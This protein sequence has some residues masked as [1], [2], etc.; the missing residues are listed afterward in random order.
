MKLAREAHALF[1]KAPSMSGFHLLGSG[2]ESL[3]VEMNGE[4]EQ[5]SDI[6]GETAT[7]D[8]GYKPQISVSPY[9]ANPDDSIYPF[10]KDLALN[11]KSGDAGLCEYMEV[12]VDDTEASTHSAWKE[13]CRVEITSYGGDTTGFQIEFNIYPNGSREEGTVASLRNPTFV[14]KN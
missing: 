4:F 7:V 10:L 13:N 2:M 3:T 9:Y 8:K 12:V 5:T 1:L 14:P 11:R 6:L